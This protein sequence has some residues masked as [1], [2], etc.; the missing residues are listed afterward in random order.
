MN[1]SDFILNAMG[2]LIYS[3]KWILDKQYEVF[4][5]RI[6]NRKLDKIQ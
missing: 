3:S 2:P 5:V 4:I 1:H 6:S